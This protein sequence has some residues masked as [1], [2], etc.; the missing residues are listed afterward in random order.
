MNLEKIF[1]LF[2]TAFSFIDLNNIEY[3]TAGISDDGISYFT[4]TLLNGLPASII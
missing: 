2:S 4:I 1:C 3:C